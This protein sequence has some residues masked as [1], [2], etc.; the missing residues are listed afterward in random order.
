MKQNMLRTFTT[1]SNMNMNKSLLVAL[2]LLCLPALVFPQAAGVTKDIQLG[3]V[4]WKAADS[5][6]EGEGSMGWAVQGLTSYMGYELAGWS[7]KAWFLGVSSHTDTAGFTQAPMV[8]GC[9]QWEI[10]YD[11]LVFPISDE[12]GITIHRYYKNMPPTVVTDGLRNTQQYPQ[13]AADHLDPNNDIIPGNADAM[14]ESWMN[15]NMGITIHQRVIAYQQEKHDDY[16]LFEW[17]FKNTGNVD[18]DADIEL[19]DQVLEDVYFMRQHR[20]EA[21]PTFPWLTSFGE[22]TDETW[23]EDF[24]DG[25]RNFFLSYSYPSHAE[26]GLFEGDWDNLAMTSVDE[27]GYPEGPI[28][29]GEALIF[30]SAAVNDMVNHDSNQPWAHFYENTDLEVVTLAPTPGSASYN[31]ERFENC[32]QFMQEGNSWYVGAELAGFTKPEMTGATIK[33]G[34]F[35]QR[36]DELWEGVNDPRDGL[37]VPTFGQIGWYVP[38]PIYVVGPYTL[39]P[40]DSF[41]VVWACVEG[42]ISSEIAWEYGNAWSH[43]AL[44]LDDLPPNVT[45]NGDYPSN[46]PMAVHNRDTDQE[47]ISPLGDTMR[48]ENN[49]VRD[50][51]IYTGKDSIFNHT[52]AAV[53]AYNNDYVIPEAPPAPSTMVTSSANHILIE[54]SHAMGDVSQI[55]GYRVY[56]FLGTTF[57]E[58]QFSAD[59]IYGLPELVY[60]CGEGTDNPLGYSFQDE[61]VIR[62]F[63]YYY[64]VT[65]VDDGNNI[66]DYDGIV[67]R[68]ESN[69]FQG[70]SNLSASLLRAPGSSLEGIKIVPNPWSIGSGE[71][72]FPGEDYK[73]MFYEVPPYCK[74]RI[75]TLDLVREIN[76][77]DGSGDQPWG[78]TAHV[79]LTTDQDQRVVSGLYFVQFEVSENH[80]DPITG[81]RLFTKGES[82]VKKLVVIR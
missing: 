81:E 56:R 39:A 66:P 43:N 42:N 53:W 31:Q 8:T 52:Y 72:Q 2:C 19:P 12:D 79:Y 3:S 61:D 49:V 41:K 82:I 44:E 58:V 27:R 64:V 65:A 45:M 67:R 34:H 48:V 62:G 17:T 32:Y 74:I 63:A 40:G 46:F 10:D 78:T 55:S 59:T 9:A 4:Y 6:D 20:I 24:A 7:S 35:M 80:D 38:S 22:Y 70:R 5:G 60:E 73:I 25:P 30:A 57:P 36:F 50:S 1:G 47:L 16:A 75:F 28:Y 71:F 54:W 33:P 11:H 23:G 77:G 18:Y 29:I 68:L 76:H 51:W 13:D 21:W 14:L 15:T 26:N 69:K 37:Y